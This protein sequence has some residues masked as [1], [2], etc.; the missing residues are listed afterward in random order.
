MSGER[1]VDWYPAIDPDVDDSL[2]GEPT[3]TASPA[4]PSKSLDGLQNGD[5]R[6][7][8]VVAKATNECWGPVDRFPPLR[9]PSTTFLKALALA[10]SLICGAFLCI[11]V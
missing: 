7:D 11:Y 3:P 9:M 6:W 1:P 4:A 2:F 10:L 5:E 8:V